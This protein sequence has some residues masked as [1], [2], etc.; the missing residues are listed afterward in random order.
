MATPATTVRF[1]DEGRDVL[2]EVLRDPNRQAL[3]GRTGTF[4][5]PVADTPQEAPPVVEQPPTTSTETAAPPA[6]VVSTSTAPPVA[7]PPVEEK[8]YAGKF[9]SIEDFEKGYKELESYSTKKAQEAATARKA[10][11]ERERVAPSVPKTDEETAAERLARVNAMLTDPDK[12]FAEQAKKANEA[13]ETER[14]QR[15]DSEQ[16]MDTWR[17]QNKDM[18]G[19]LELGEEKIPLEQFVGAEMHRITSSDPN[20]DP[21]AALQKATTNIRAAVGILIDRGRKEAL[22]VQGSVTQTSA[23]KINVPPPTEQPSKAPVTEQDAFQAHLASLNANAAS[24]RR[25]VR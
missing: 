5:E 10:L 24:V 13:I 23:A 8:T 18:T 9:K 6:P 11:E 15:R 14:R 2:G 1:K 20:I 21:V 4:F 7:P 17:E 16:I 3:D 25:P 19:N 12:Y 22:S